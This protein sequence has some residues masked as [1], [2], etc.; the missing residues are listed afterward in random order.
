MLF[1]MLKIFLNFPKRN[2][3][4]D[5][6]NYTL[7]LYVISLFSLLCFLSKKLIFCYWKTYLQFYIL[8]FNI[9]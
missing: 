4:V 1:N 5:N 3:H 7:Y 8:L 9:S 2:L 6:D